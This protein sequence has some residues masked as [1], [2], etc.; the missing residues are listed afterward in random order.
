MKYKMTEQYAKGEEKPLAE[1]SDLNDAKLFVAGKSYSDEVAHERRIYRLYDT[2]QLLA[3]FNKEKIQA[4]I[5]RAQFAEGDRD[6]PDSLSL[7]FKIT[8]RLENKKE[9]VLAG[10]D[11]IEDANLF[12]ANKFDKDTSIRADDIFCLYRFN[13]LVDELTKN[14]LSQRKVEETSN[15]G[16]EKK[17]VFR[18][19]PLKMRPRLGPGGYWVEE[20]EDDENK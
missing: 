19:S 17:M 10:L 1:F 4:I 11:T 5:E 8:R 18:P 13:G 9:I 15:K 2:D 20:D 7:P 6:L 16:N 3:E 12:I 14:I